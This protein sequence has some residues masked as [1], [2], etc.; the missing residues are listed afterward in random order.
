VSILFFSWSG[1]VVLNWKD[2]LVLNKLLG[3]EIES[4]DI[5]KTRITQTFAG[6]QLAQT[7]AFGEAFCWLGLTY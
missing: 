2:R 5:S 1:E 7:K 4:D 3:F 6:I